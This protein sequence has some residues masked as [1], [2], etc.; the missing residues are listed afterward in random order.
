MQRVLKGAE[1]LGEWKFNSEPGSV[2]GKGTIGT[3]YLLC[4]YIGRKK[5]LRDCAG[6]AKVQ[7][8][9]SNRELI[10]FQNEVKAQKEFQ[11]IGPEIHGTCLIRK[12]KQ[13]YGIIV[14]EKIDQT[15]DQYL[16]KRRS[17]DA[18]NKVGEQMTAILAELKSRKLTHGDL[19]LF[20][21]GLIGERLVL[22]DFDRAAV[23]PS[24][25]SPKVDLLRLF[26]EFRKSTQAR[27]TKKTN[28]KN[29][30][31]IRNNWF[32]AWRVALGIS[33][34]QVDVKKSA[35]EHDAMWTREYRKYCVKAKVKCL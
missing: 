22:I 30:T 23:K 34:R 15:L 5:K 7:R 12:K 21:V 31:F 3:V 8:L 19:A 17:R 11:G 16:S 1:C 13:N 10:M 14:M 29:L 9:G 35:K 25:Y 4:R 2:L 24:E 33:K 6:A 18:L 27:G 26:V 32:E 28:S 20:N